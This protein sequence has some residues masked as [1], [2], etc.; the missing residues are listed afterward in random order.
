MATAAYAAVPT[1][2]EP[3]SYLDYHA[4]RFAFLLDAVATVARPDSAILDIGRSPFT[5]MLEQ[6]YADV[7]TLGFGPDADNHIV[8][9]LNNAATGRI[10]TERQY[11]VIVFA[12]VI[13]HLYTAPETVLARLGEILAPGGVI[14][15]QTPNAVDLI[16]RIKLLV[17]RNPYERIRTD[18]TNPGH[19]REYT[20]AEL[21][22]VARA[23]GYEVLSH[24]FAEY[25]G[26][27]QRGWR[28]AIGLP[29]L[30]AVA[31]L[32][33]PLARG[34]TVILRRH[35]D[36]MPRLPNTPVNGLITR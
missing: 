31:A 35:Q 21:F 4:R 22:E 8:Y 15:V 34:Q 7:S 27:Y 25:F 10:A 32:W 33:P 19:F 16:K 12:E 11:D 6:R 29:F 26:S 3:V 1:A 18:T 2:P 30:R 23:A 9:D 36:T 13:E 24:S 14:I 28:G 17:G 20:K 5:A